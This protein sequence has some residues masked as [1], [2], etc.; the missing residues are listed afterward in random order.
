MPRPRVPTCVILKSKKLIMSCVVCIEGDDFDVDAV[1]P[2]LAS[3]SP[4]LRVAVV[5]RGEAHRRGREVL[6]AAASALNLEIS[7]A[8][9]ANL[10][11]ELP[12]IRQFLQAHAA[13]LSWL[14][15]APDVQR[16][17]VKVVMQLHDD[18]NFPQED[19]ALPDDIIR[20]LAMAGLRFRVSFASE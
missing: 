1:L 10:S 5:R 8:F 19:E 14:T 20:V 12:L 16:A 15:H 17:Y 18:A 3:E 6:V 11:S 2:R 7:P 4:Q 9:F 13:A